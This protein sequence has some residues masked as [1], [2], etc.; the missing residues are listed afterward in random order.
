VC[1]LYCYR[2]ENIKSY[3]VVLYDTLTF[4]IEG[5]SAGPLYLPGNILAA[6]QGG[7]LKIEVI[8]PSE[9]LVLT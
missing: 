8:R 2:R 7:I 5:D 6:N 3:I 1:I 9:T 4:A